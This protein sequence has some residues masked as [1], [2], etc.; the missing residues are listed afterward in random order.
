VHR[1]R[2]GANGAAG[3]QRGLGWRLLRADNEAR[4]SPAAPRFALDRSVTVPAQLPGGRIVPDHATHGDLLR[5][6]LT[7]SDDATGFDRPWSPFGIVWVAAIGG[8]LPSGVLLALNFRR[9]GMARW[10]LPTL[11]I[12]AALTLLLD[13]VV[14]YAATTGQ[15][16]RL[17]GRW[18]RFGLK[19]FAIAFALAFAAAQ[20]RR[21]R[22]FGTT[23]QAPGGLLNP[24]LVAIGVS[25]VVTF[26]YGLLIAA[27][28]RR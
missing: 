24:A 17:T 23:R 4:D 13:G 15:V 25:M 8:L 27:L 11:A 16:D 20:S 19:A 5:P 28:V 12:T 18:L 10:T 26:G 21:F 6:S 22:L 7:E 3:A 14:M 2:R 1:A 9:L